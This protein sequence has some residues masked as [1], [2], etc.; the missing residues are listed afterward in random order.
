MKRR[1]IPERW[2]Q[3]I[4]MLENQGGLSVDQIAQALKVSSATVRRDLALIHQR[5]LIKR[6][7]GGAEPSPQMR[8]DRTLSESRKINPVEK[9]IIGAATAELICS[10]DTLMVDGGF[11]TYQVA[12]Q[13]SVGD[14]TVVTNSIDVVNAMTNRDDVTLVIIGGELNRTS[15][16]TVGPMTE[17]QLLLLRADKAI[18][19]ANA[20]SPEEGVSSPNPY[21]AQTKRAMVRG[22][23]EVIVVADH[24]KLGKLAAYSVAPIESISVLVTDDKA[25]NEILDAFRAA[26]VE[27]IVASA[28]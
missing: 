2:E 21:T 16:T 10:G 24:S 27:V 17:S 3:I 11:T 15:G 8:E 20:I 22:S 1:I 7:R 19:G 12:R 25:N 5:G 9:E 28:E 4:E 23:R 26:G 13:V 6:T 14:I 18:L